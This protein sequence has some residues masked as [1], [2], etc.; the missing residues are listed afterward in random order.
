MTDFAIQTPKFGKDENT[1]S[2]L[3]KEAFVSDGSTDIV[4]IDGEYRHNLGRLPDLLDSDGVQICA[5][6][7]IFAITAVD[8]GAKKFTIGTNEAATITANAVNNKIRINASTGNDAL[9]TID[10]VTD[11]ASTTEIVVTETIA[12]ATVDGNMFVGAT[13]IQA[14]LRYVRQTNDAEFFLVATTYNIFS[15]VNS[16]KQLQVKF[17]SG[18][19]G[20]GTRWELQEHLDN[21][22]ATNNVDLVQK[23]ATSTAPSG[24]FGDLGSATGIVVGDVE[25]GGSRKITKAKHLASFQSYLH[26]GRVTYDNSDVRPQRTH[27][28]SLGDTTDFDVTGA[29]DAGSNDFTNKEGFL[30]GYGKWSN[31]LIVFTTDL[32]YEGTL[33]TDS[34]VFNWDEAELKVGS[35]SADTIVNDPSGRLYWLAS[36]QTI[37]EFR[38]PF[39]ISEGVIK[40]LRNL[41]TTVAE[42]AQAVYNEA[43]KSV[44]F[45]IPVTQ[46]ATNNVIVEFFIESGS[47]FIHNIPVRSF[48]KF[49][50]QETFSYDNPPFSTS[51]DTYAEWGGSW[52][53]YD[54]N[55]SVQG[56]KLTMAADY[57]GGIHE[58]NGAITDAGNLYT[59]TL[60]FSSTLTQIKDLIRRKRVNNG[61]HA[62]FTRK[63]SGVVAFS[64]KGKSKGSYQALGNFSLANSIATETVTP[65][66]PFDVADT[67]F[68]WR[69]QTTADMAFLALYFREFN[70]EDIR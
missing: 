10:T 21:I 56:F 42:F 22:Y 5:P 28:S 49:T 31:M 9:Y 8:Q 66:L 64:V 15:W 51:F 63:S 33:V 61:A 24:S 48:G 3:L 43:Q 62:V 19:P 12:D 16:S 1:P 52:G 41:N 50:R 32:H 23:W 37:K 14:Q 54:L 59:S 55:R 40:T 29:G 68:L 25:G 7:N 27:W 4:E 11:V 60:I 2:V 45:A 17:T 44:M 35:F 58:Y 57:N 26:I 53:V 69:L 18:S 36:D 70:I 20:T 65:H 67:Q 34:L 47:M 30:M 13:P 39:D 38:T 46:S 6:I